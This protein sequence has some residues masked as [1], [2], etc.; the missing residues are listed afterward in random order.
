[1]LASLT[2][3]GFGPT[4]WGLQLL[5]AT[6]MTLAVSMAAYAVGMAFGALA[7]GIRAK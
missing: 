6:A 5:R 2:L 7:Q 3:L 1:M 4:G